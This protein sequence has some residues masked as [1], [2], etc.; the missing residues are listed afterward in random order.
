MSKYAN[1]DAQRIR[2]SGGSVR[3]TIPSGLT[4]QGNGGTSLPCIGCWVSPAS[5]NTGI[6]K[7]NIDTAASATLGIELSDADNGSGPIWVPIDDVA[8]LYFYSA[9][10]GNFIDITYLLG[11]S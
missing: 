2:G 1:A 3:I 4:G 10:S 5:G 6:T 9:T 11:G 7:M 8:S